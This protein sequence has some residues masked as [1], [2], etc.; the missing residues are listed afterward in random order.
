MSDSKLKITM[1]KI[2]R[3]AAIALIAL[4]TSCDGFLTVDEKGKATIPSFLSDPRGLH[5]GLLGQQQLRV[6]RCRRPHHAEFRIL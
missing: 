2:I 1:H 5:A 4:L 3:Y 6:Q